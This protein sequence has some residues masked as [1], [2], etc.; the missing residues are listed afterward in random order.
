MTNAKHAPRPA[1]QKIREPPCGSLEFTHVNLCAV[2]PAAA[3]YFL[4]L[5]L[6]LV[7][8]PFPSVSRLSAAM[9]FRQA[10]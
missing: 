1:A 3:V 5:S 6:I 4:V 2:L 8:R 7:L 10:L 9:P